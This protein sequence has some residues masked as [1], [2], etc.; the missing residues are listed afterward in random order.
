MVSHLTRTVRTCKLNLPINEGQGSTIHDSSGYG[1]HGTIYGATWTKG[2]YGYGLYFDGTDDYVDCGN[3]DLGITTQVT[4]IA[5]VRFDEVARGGGIENRQVI[6][7]LGGDGT[8][9]YQPQDTPAR[10]SATAYDGTNWNDISIGAGAVTADTWYM[11]ANVINCDTHTHTL[12]LNDMSVSGSTGD[13]IYDTTVIK[14]GGI[15]YPLHGTI[16]EVLIYNRA[17]ND[18]EISQ[19]YKVLKNWEQNIPVT[20]GLVLGLTPYSLDC[21]NGIWN[22]ISGNNNNATL[23]GARCLWI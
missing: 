9:I 11:V 17:L 1:N 22:D 14:L 12:F 23:Y 4:Q 20:D 3:N 2:S 5:W 15:A 10:I 19:I 7:R 18:T 21:E 8:M 16:A 6:V 13:Q